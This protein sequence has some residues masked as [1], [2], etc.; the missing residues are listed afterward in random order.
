MVPLIRPL[1]LKM[2]KLVMKL[3]ILNCLKTVIL[4]PQKNPSF[5]SYYKPYF[6]DSENGNKMMTSQDFKVLP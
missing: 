2:V 3:I 4:P 6:C 1:A 5:S